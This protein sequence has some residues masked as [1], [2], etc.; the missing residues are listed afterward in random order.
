[1]GLLEWELRFFHED[2]DTNLACLLT[3]LYGRVAR[4]SFT[5]VWKDDMELDGVQII[6]SAKHEAIELL[7]A[8]WSTIGRSRYSTKD[9][10]GAAEH[11]LVRRLEKLL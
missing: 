1:M 3:N 4:V 8:E 10:F 5:S 11:A 2:L 6:M 9:E 7:I